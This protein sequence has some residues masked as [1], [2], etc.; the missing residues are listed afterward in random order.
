VGDPV[1]VE[2]NRHVVVLTLN[3]P[4]AANAFNRAMLAAF[5]D[6]VAGLAGDAE[7]RA[8]VITAAGEKVFCAGADLKERAAMDLDGVRAAV[9]S[10]RAGLDALARLPMPTIAA[11]NGAALGGGLELALACDLRVASPGT[12]LGLTE[13]TLAIIPG[14][15]GTQRLPRLVGAGNAKDLILTGRRIDADEALRIGLVNEIA[16]DPRARAMQMAARIAENGPIAVR[17]AKEAIDA[18]L[19]LPMDEALALE[20]TLYERT[21]GTNDRVEGL[22]SFREKRAPEYRGE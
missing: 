8:V 9:G 5:G 16:D 22:T 1:L 6:A 3:R 11:M 18:G 14:G 19:P 21:I 12:S 2:R 10:I 4:E 20:G 17:A 13:T 15:G 7:A